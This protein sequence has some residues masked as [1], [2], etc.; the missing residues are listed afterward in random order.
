MQEFEWVT[1]VCWVIEA[2][3]AVSEKG[4]KKL[5]FLFFQT[6]WKLKMTKFHTY[7]SFCLYTYVSAIFYVDIYEQSIKVG[8][9]AKVIFHADI[10]GSS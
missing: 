2:C 10:C 5:S 8:E 1:G 9:R 4:M 3:V 7:F 6:I